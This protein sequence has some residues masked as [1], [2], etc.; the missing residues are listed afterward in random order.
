MEKKLVY[1]GKTKDVVRKLNLMGN[2]ILVRNGEYYIIG[3]LY[4]GNGGGY[5]GAS[6]FTDVTCFDNDIYVC[7]DRNRGRLFG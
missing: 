5:Q 2:D 6:Y 3:D 1:K 7:L 4:M